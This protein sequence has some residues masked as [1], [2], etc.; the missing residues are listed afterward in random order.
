M[1][2][3]T[4]PNLEDDQDPSQVQISGASPT[5]EQSGGGGSPSGQKKL[6]TGSGFQ[7]LDKYLQTNQAGQFGQ[8]VLGNVQGEVDQAKQGMEKGAQ[9]F[10]AQVQDANKT[11]TMDQVNQAIADPTQADAK[12]FQQWQSQQYGG[13]K[14]LAESK[15]SWNQ[16]WSGANKANT[17]AQQLG[18]ESGRFSLLDSYFGRPN[19]SFGEKSLDNL[20]VQQSGLG[21]ETRNIQNEA[22]G[23]KTVGNQKAMDLQNQAAQRA[24]EVEQSRKGVR[25]AIGL[26]DQGNVITGEGAGAIGQQY[27]SVEQQLAAENAQRKAEMDRIAG[28]VGN[29]QLSADDISK[30]GLDAGMNLYDINLRDY[31]S[32]GQLEL[33]KDQVM[34]PEQRARIQALSQMAG[35]TDTFASGEAQDK[36]DLYSFNADQAKQAASSSKAQYERQLQEQPVTFKYS[37]GSP[38]TQTMAKMRLGIQQVKADIARGNNSNSNKEYLKYAEPALAQAESNLANQFKVDRKLSAR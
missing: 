10:S 5:T 28:E 37:T 16:Y 26:D 2:F 38:V 11:P 6:D 30:L 8:K 22:A 36:G 27:Q 25:S 17:T 7:N 15:D 23:L 33:N 14:N 32:P 4:D 34:T 21:R 3:F 19:Y 18:S 29:D 31:L 35:V 1:P 13:P 12:Q 20:L 24:G 9:Q